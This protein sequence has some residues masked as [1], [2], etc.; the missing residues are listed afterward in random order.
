MNDEIALRL[1]EALNRN[2]D[3]MDRFTKAQSSLTGV[4][5]SSQ[6]VKQEK[7]AEKKRQA[8]TRSEASPVLDEI[9]GLYLNRKTG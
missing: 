5:S 9:E 1:I 8:E 7:Q 2:S 4:I 3:S 6:E